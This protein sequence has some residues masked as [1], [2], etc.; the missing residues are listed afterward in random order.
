MKAV[1]FA[2]G[3]GTRLW[4]LSRRSSPKQ[5][6]KVVSDKSTL[7]LAVNRLYPD[8]K[9]Q[10][11][12]ISTGEQ[13]A[14]IV[15][16]QLPEIPPEHVIGEPVMRDVGPAVG[17]VAAIMAK[18]YPHE[19]MA[20]LWSD[21][22]VR[23]EELFRKVLKVAE[24][25]ILE[26]K[27]HIVFISQKPRFANQNLGWIKYGHAAKT[28][29][30]IAIY[31]F[32]SLRY[33]PSI[34]EA[35]KYFSGSNY[36]WN[37]GYFVTSPE[38]LLAQYE[39]FA[40]DMYQELK[41]IQSEWKTPRFAS[42][43]KKIYPKLESIHFDNI[44]LEKLQKENASVITENIEWSDVGAWEALKE[45]LQVSPEQNVTQGKV[46]TVDARDSLVYNYT[47][48]MIV[49]I[50]LDGFMVVNMHDVLL[51]CHKDSVPKIKKLVNSFMGT[52]NEHLT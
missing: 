22:L 44:I 13:Y 51:I 38:F 48:Q 49:G 8:F 5:F 11:I 40:P 26:K 17:L 23:K 27:D 31:T 37:L 47:N 19:P 1:I 36:A 2:G 39:A 33:R 14:S 20:I 42:T 46:L 16:R 4:P 30:G 28:V 35:K 32:D 45:A 9:A 18:E 24:T 12:F 41:T 6:E 7:Q 10:D 52:E 3:T 50:D 21:H 15:R 25:I 34:D 43:L 29:D